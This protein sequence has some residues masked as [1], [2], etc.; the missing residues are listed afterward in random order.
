[1]LLL[2]QKDRGFNETLCLLSGSE[3]P[4]QAGLSYRGLI[5]SSFYNLQKK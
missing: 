2:I 1:M 3:I 4:P 5:A